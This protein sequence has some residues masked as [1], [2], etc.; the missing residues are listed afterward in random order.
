VSPKKSGTSVK[1]GRN[2]PW[3][4]Y[5]VNINGQIFSTFDST[6][7]NLIGQSG[8]F[9]YQTST[10]SVNGKN[11][12]NNT[13][14]NLNKKPSSSELVDAIRANAEKLDKILSILEQRLPDMDSDP[15]MNVPTEGEINVDDIPF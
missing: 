5:E 13:L 11:Y 7:Q 10:R 4:I 9:D 12:T 8:T 15:D 1:N 6:Y 14:A 3:T 2:I